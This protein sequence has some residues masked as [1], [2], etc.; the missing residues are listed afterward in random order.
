MALR[1]LATGRTVFAVPQEQM[2]DISP[3]ATIFRY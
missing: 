1:P 3:V 2:P